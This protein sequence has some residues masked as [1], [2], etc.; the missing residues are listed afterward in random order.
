[1]AFT[2]RCGTG[3]LKV[4]FIELAMRQS[5]INKLLRFKWF[6]DLLRF[7]V[8]G[9]CQITIMLWQF[10]RTSLPVCAAILDLPR[11]EW[12]YE[13][14]DQHFL[15]NEST[16]SHTTNDKIAS[17]G[18]CSD[19]GFDLAAT[20]QKTGQVVICDDSGLHWSKTWP[21]KRSSQACLAR[22]D[23][24]WPQFL[25]RLGGA[26]QCIYIYMQCMQSNIT[27]YQGSSNMKLGKSK[28]VSRKALYLGRWQQLW[29]PFIRH[30]VVRVFPLEQHARKKQLRN[31]VAHVLL[32]A[33]LETCQN[34][35]NWLNLSRHIILLTH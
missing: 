26:M 15:A 13:A 5:S 4:M 28:K 20:I 6:N 9:S 34:M 3:R 10:D 24:S 16:K 17:I 35:I 27:N 29:C 8:E 1:M 21:K 30:R 11:F 12:R 19:L 22:Q 33:M 7:N 32:V 14:A 23:R 25:S 18:F 2:P 31:H